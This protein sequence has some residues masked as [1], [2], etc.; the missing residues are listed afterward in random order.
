MNAEEQNRRILV[1]AFPLRSLSPKVDDY[2]LGIHETDFPRVLMM[3]LK[4]SD[5]CI[6]LSTFALSTLK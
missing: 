3:L 2:N 6:A 4:V 5:G 1:K